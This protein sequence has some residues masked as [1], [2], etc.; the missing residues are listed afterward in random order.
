MQ[1]CKQNAR[2]PKRDVRI[3]RQNNAYLFT[4]TGTTGQYSQDILYTADPSLNRIPIDKVEDIL[5]KCETGEVINKMP[6]MDWQAVAELHNMVQKYQNHSSH[7]PRIQLYWDEN[8]HAVFLQW[9]NVVGKSQLL[10]KG[11]N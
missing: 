9:N 5:R 10:M 6:A 8:E 1:F 2:S 4:A 11:M 3:E 7:R